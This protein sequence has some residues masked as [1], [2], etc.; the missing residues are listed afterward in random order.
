MNRVVRNMGFTLIELM[1][2]MVFVSALLVMVAV[3]TIQISNI[4]NR[5]LLLKADNEAASK[6]MD[7]LQRQISSSKS[8]SPDDSSHLVKMPAGTGGRLCLGGYSY[9]WNYGEA[10]DSS[11]APSNLSSNVY[12]DSDVSIRLVKVRDSG[13]SYCTL[14]GSSYP[15]VS[16]SNAT[17]L[18]GG[19]D[20]PLALQN[21]SVESDEGASDALTG[22]R[23][24][25]ISFT[26]GTY[27]NGLVNYSAEVPSCKVPSDVNGDLSYCYMNKFEMTA[28]SGGEK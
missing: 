28:R 22:Q 21:F 12:S 26:L 4:Y 17:E 23:L 13:G 7:D 24:Y 18:L 1:L 19:T 5:G 2:A 15:K 14:S 16:K 6:I 3:I 25:Y 10:L 9:I 27:G 11:N 8:F 20:L